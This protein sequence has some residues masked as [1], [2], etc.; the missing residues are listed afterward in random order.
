M[1]EVNI[2]T[3]KE[4]LNLHIKKKAC[5]TMKVENTD[6][7]LVSFQEG[8]HGKKSIS[9]FQFSSISLPLFVTKPLMQ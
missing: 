8:V 5:K 1:A 9:V 2:G 3:Y 4:F 6:V 7:R